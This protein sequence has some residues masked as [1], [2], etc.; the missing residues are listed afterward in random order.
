MKIFI[1]IL[2]GLLFFQQLASQSSMEL[3]SYLP[4]IEGWTIDKK[5]ETF[6]ENNL[7]DRINGSAP[8]FIE[9]NFREMTS[10]E[11]TRGDD[12]ITIQA[13]RHASPEDAFG[14]YA[15]E[16]STATNFLPIGGEAHGY[17]DAL[18][19]FAGNIYVKINASESGTE[20]AQILQKIGKGFANNIDPEA[21]YP[22]IFNFFPTERKI[23][24]KESYTT[25]SYIGHPFLK[26]VY[27]AVYDKS[28]KEFQL[29]ILDAGTKE[30]AK[31]ILTEYFTFTK[32]D[33]E[34]K[35]G[36][37][38]IKDRYNGD[39]PCIWK[40]QYITG[41]FN[42]SGEDMNEEELLIL[43]ASKL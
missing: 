19:F 14:M 18:Y 34:F 12:Y 15:S 13:Y 43:L 24:H 3:R 39:I 33:K 22:E 7:F 28:G 2:T 11:Y 32:Q 17:D 9:N 5:I 40:G 21:G 31:D 35:E 41:I 25:S 29:F 30:K 23:P 16:R 20:T 6:D 27:S 1:S 8:L 36:S 26:G 4:E 10:M 37:L 38:L 42:E